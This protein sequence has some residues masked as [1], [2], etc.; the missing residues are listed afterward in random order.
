MT[1][2]EAE[3]TLIER[4]LRRHDG[5]ISEAARSLG[6]SRSALYRRLKTHGL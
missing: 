5:N 6:L 2:P 1:L 3:R 4:A